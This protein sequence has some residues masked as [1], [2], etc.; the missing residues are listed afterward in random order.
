MQKFALLAIF[1]I[2]V[3]FQR[4]IILS[5]L[6]EIQFLEKELCREIKSTFLLITLKMKPCNKNK[7]ERHF[8]IAIRF[9][10]LEKKFL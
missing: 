1:T 5:K 3:H 10:L 7:I 2:S 9:S 6:T 4:I 8:N